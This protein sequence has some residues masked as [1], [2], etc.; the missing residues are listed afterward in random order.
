MKFFPILFLQ[1]KELS[2]FK[3]SINIL[4]TTLLK[5]HIFLW[6]LERKG[7]CNIEILK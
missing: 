3:Q 2:E 7:A 6:S 4:Y 5:V 1:E